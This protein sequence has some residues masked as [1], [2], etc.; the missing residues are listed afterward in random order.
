MIISIDAEK[1]SDKIQH[2][3]IIKTQGNWHSRTYLKIIKGIPDKPIA[4]IFSKVKKLKY[5]H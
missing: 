1:A 5:F 3:F 2:S 4:N